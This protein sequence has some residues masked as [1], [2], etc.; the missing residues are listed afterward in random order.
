MNKQMLVAV[1]VALGLG[2]GGGYLAPRLS[3]H[4]AKVAKEPAKAE[5]KPLFYRNPMNPQITSPVPAKDDMG[6]EYIPVYADE[7][8]GDAAPAG[9]VTISSGTVQ[10][11]G[12]RTYKAT[13]RNMTHDIRAVGRVDYDEERLARLHPKIEG[14]VGKQWVGETG[15]QVK[16]G[17]ILLSIYS[18]QLVSSQEEYLLA[19]KSAETF[20]NSPY[21][22]ISKGATDLARSARER[23]KLLD[24]P[25]HQI[26][27]LENTREVSKYLH[28]HSPFDG[29]IVNIGAREGQYVTPGTELYLI[30]DLSTVWVFAEIYENEQPW[31]KVGDKAQIKVAALPGRP[32]S[33]RVDYIYPYMDSKTRT[34]KLRIKLDNRDRSLKPD[35]FADVILGTDSKKDAIAIPEEAVVRS[36]KHEQVFVQKAP[37]KFE[38]REVTLGLASGGMV[39]IVRGVNAGELVVASAQFLIDSESKLREAT[40]KMMN[41]ATG[42][43]A[44]PE[45]EAEPAMKQEPDANK[46]SGMNVEPAQEH[47]HHD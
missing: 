33:G 12:I 2:I 22:D 8:A 34:V 47:H 29:V 27:E 16:K 23:L 25:E 15:E 9:T 3:E 44:E 6:M 19:L 24:V 10:N 36:G 46:T 5:K 38:P 1:V 21:A 35:M 30:A 13:R 20:K 45:P 7:A 40:A 18:P 41:P 26:M 39:E 32:F 43:I 42:T 37:G 17:T 14:W 31:V 11:I 4:E 28:I